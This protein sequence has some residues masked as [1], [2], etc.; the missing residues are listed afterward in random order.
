MTEQEEYRTEIEAKLSTSRRE[1]DRLTDAAIR[2]W[3]EGNRGLPPDQVRKRYLTERM[4]TPEERAQLDAIET[5]IEG[6]WDMLHRFF[7]EKPTPQER[8][9][10]EA[11]RAGR[12]LR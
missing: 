9:D 12:K 5:R 8:A 3:E 2:R 4:F 1:K 6:Y 11:G 7:K 10:D